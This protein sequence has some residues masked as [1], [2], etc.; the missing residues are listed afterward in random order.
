MPIDLTESE[1]HFYAFATVP[2]YAVAEIQRSRRG[3][4]AA[5]LRSWRY[6]FEQTGLDAQDAKFGNRDG[7]SD[8]FEGHRRGESDAQ[9][10]V[11]ADGGFQDCVAARRP[12]CAVELN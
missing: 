9:S 7:T 1:G 12:F 2:G 10:S 3:L 11:H 4:L 5:D 8:A 6:F